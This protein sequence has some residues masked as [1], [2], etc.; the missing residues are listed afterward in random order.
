MNPKPTKLSIL[1]GV[2]T[3]YTTGKISVGEKILV[4]LLVLGY[5]FFPIDLIPDVFPVIGWL[6][7]IGIG[8]L[9]LAFCNW[10]C[11]KVIAEEGKDTKSG[12]DIQPEPNTRE[13]EVLPVMEPRKSDHG[14]PSLLTSSAKSREESIFSPKK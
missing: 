8:A 9:F 3:Y 2:L 10:R 12:E 13:K 1:E 11:N 6:D 5:V 4:S 7:D 14:A